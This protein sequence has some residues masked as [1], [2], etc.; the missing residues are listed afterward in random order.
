MKIIV[1]G[2]SGFVGKNYINL[3]KN[4]QIQAVSLSKSELFSFDFQGC[5][6]LLH[7]AALVHQMHGAPEGE[8]FKIN[9]DLA[10]ATAQKAKKEG[11]KHFILLSTVKV[12][13]ES[14]TNKIPLNEK[15]D[16]HPEDAY[17]KS[18]LEAEKRIF[19]LEDENFKVAIIR[20]PLV[21]GTGVKANMFNL[22]K[23]IDKMPILP[24]GNITNKRSFVYIENLIALIDRIITTRASGIY[25]ARDSENLSTTELTLAI[26]KALNKKRVMLSVPCLFKKIIASLF[27]AQYDRLWGSLEVS[28]ES[29]WQKIAFIPPVSF[30]K[31]IKDMVNWYN[32]LKGRS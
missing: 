30:E 1:T 21:Y 18:K 26:S 24:F 10:F 25:L 32:S 27:P 28:P 19:G 7:L 14:T 15:T 5:E 22:I 2:A 3:N 13:G 29:G 31:G 8:Y 9:S 17:G 4:H 11:I 6:V 12:Y 23:L 20:S 16:C